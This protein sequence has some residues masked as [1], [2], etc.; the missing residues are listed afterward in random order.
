MERPTVDGRSNTEVPDYQHRL[1]VLPLQP[2]HRT[3]SHEIRGTPSHIAGSGTR[4][5]NYLER[6][7]P[8]QLHRDPF[9]LF[10]GT[11]YSICTSTLLRSSSTERFNNKEYCIV[12]GQLRI[13]ATFHH[14]CS[15]MF[16]FP[17]RRFWTFFIRVWSS[18][19]IPDTS[20]RQPHFQVF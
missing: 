11:R 8:I 7:A 15:S 2:P 12:T 16:I 1:S 18:I 20:P 19:H 13:I 3:S 9:I 10:F 5:L 6:I 14:G 4:S 17:T